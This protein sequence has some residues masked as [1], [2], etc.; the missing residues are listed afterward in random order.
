MMTMK[1][2][3]YGQQYFLIMMTMSQHI[4]PLPDQR[5]SIRHRAGLCFLGQPCQVL[6]I[7]RK[8]NTLKASEMKFCDAILNLYYNLVFKTCDENMQN[9]NKCLKTSDVSIFEFNVKYL[10]DG[11]LNPGLPRDRRGY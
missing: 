1:Y 2:N 9:N 8:K 11:E 6:G 4:F 5:C 7:V 10:P 3:I